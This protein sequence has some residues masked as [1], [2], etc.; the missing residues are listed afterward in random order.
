MKEILCFGDSNTWGFNPEDGSRLPD[1]IRWT[2]IVKSVLG[3]DYRIIEDGINGRTTVWDNPFGE[4]YRNGFKGL[5]YSLNANKPL[6]L[7]VLMLGTNDLNY[8]DA[9]GVGK[10]LY[11]ILLRLIDANRSYKDTTRG[12]SNIWRDDPRVLLVSPIIRNKK[13]S[14]GC[15]IEERRNKESILVS[16]ITKE[17]A[18]LFDVFYLDAATISSPSSI[19]GLHMDEENHRKLGLS[20]A[21]AI[22]EIFG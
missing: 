13:D 19:D 15:D 6:D 20:I 17:L 14:P 2:G 9:E 4:E 18:S 11:R 5:S 10:G 12:A 22:K 7:V 8:T 3:A 1:S 21:Q 16:A